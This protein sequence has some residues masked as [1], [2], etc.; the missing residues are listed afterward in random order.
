M[1]ASCVGDHTVSSSLTGTDPKF[2]YS[3]TASPSKVCLKIVNGASTQQI[4]N[5]TLRGL[6][7]FAHLAR[8]STLHANTT[9]ATNTI[10]DGKGILPVNTTL[11]FNGERIPF[12]AQA[13]SIQVLEVNLK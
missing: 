3:A 10:K 13:Y 11:N 2:F 12:V 7:S 6:G 9:W 1:F 8:V 4:V 5:I